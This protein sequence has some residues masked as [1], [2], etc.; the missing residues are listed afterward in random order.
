MISIV[1]LII[2]VLYFPVITAYDPIIAALLPC[3]LPYSSLII[4]EQRAYISCCA[5]IASPY[6]TPQAKP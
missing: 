3:R 4:F 6:P 2:N 1:S 5:E